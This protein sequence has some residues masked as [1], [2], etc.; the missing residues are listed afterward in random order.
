MG[1][2]L[3]KIEKLQNKCNLNNDPLFGTG[4]SSPSEIIEKVNEIID[5][6]NNHTFELKKE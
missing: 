5:F 3:R 4:Q 1:K 6:I 2:S